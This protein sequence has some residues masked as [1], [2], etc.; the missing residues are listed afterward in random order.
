MAHFLDL[1]E[2]LIWYISRIPSIKYYQFTGKNIIFNIYSASQELALGPSFHFISED[3]ET[4]EVG[5]LEPK[6]QLGT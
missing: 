6:L 4:E 1:E 2:Y 3:L 5:N